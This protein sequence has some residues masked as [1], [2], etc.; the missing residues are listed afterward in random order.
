MTARKHAWDYGQVIYRAAQDCADGNERTEK[1]CLHCGLVKITVHPP[2]GR[3]W[4]EWRTRENAVYVGEA[5]PP[6]VEIARAV[7][8]KEAVS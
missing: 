8:I 7:E 4:H 2:Y 6:C 3:P 1:P 5:T